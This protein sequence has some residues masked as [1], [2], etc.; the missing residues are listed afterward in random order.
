MNLKEVRLIRL[1]SGILL[2]LVLLF[3]LIFALVIPAVK[4]YKSVRESFTAQKERFERAKERY[5]TVFDRYRALK[6][7][8]RKVLEAF[9]NRWDEARFAQTAQSYFDTFSMRLLE[10][11]ATDGRYRLYEINAKTSM[12]TPRKFYNFL[13]ALP[14]MPYVVAADFPIAFQAVDNRTIEGVFR[15][16]VYEERGENNASNSSDANASKR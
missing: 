15:V 8:H 16:R 11:N 9:E 6:A 7:K 13:D 5:D 1:L 3:I 2:Y 10:N 4:S 12:D 14:N